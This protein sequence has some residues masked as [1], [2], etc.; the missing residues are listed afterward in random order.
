M[1]GSSIDVITI[2]YDCRKRR[3]NLNIACIDYQKAFDS[4]P[5]T[6]SWIEKSTELAEMNNKIVKFWKLS[7]DRWSTRLQLQINKGLMQSRCIK[8][9]MGI[10]L[11]VS[12]SP[13]LCIAFTPLTHKLN[14]SKC[15]YKLCETE[16]NISHFLYTDDLKLTG[17]REEKLRN[18]NQNCNTNYQR[19]KNGVWIR[20]CSGI[21]FCNVARFIESKT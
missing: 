14:T 5:H 6:C 9:N 2:F 7:M 3:M 1:Q 20:I 17:R 21:L 4:V 8:I 15:R 11:G 18:G 12:L 13:L 19:C 16:T 10:F